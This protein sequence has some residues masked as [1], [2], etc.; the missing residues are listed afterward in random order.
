MLKD[1]K[2][3]SFG[4]GGSIKTN[5]ENIR[6]RLSRLVRPGEGRVGDSPTDEY[7]KTREIHQSTI[8]ALYQ[9]N[10][11]EPDP[12][13]LYKQPL[14]D[15][16]NMSNERLVNWLQSHSASSSYRAHQHHDNPNNWLQSHSASSSYRAHQHH[17]KPPHSL[18]TFFNKTSINLYNTKQKDETKFYF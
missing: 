7:R 9:Q 5:L 14:G 18:K 8:T 2:K 17:D 4:M 6:K 15:I 3:N 11:T 1:Q 10:S 13:A 12:H 16:L